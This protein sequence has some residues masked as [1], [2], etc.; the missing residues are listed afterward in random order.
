MQ[1]II[2]RKVQIQRHVQKKVV[3]AKAQ[4]EWNVIVKDELFEWHEK[5]SLLYQ[6]EPRVYKSIIKNLRR[7]M[8]RQR[9]ERRKAQRISA[10]SI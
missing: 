6:N 3:N 1:K 9:A 2:H 7:R 5:T 10:C 4:A 8:L